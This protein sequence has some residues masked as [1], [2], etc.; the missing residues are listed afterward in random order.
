MLN[1]IIIF[2]FEK[3]GCK[4]KNLRNLVTTMHVN[5]NVQ[6]IVYRV[7]VLEVAHIV[8]YQSRLW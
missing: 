4:L 5:Y 7:P 6:Y 1:T 3:Y 2:L 8:L